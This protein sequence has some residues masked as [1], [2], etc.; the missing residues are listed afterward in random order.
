MPIFDRFR[1]GALLLGAAA[2]AA[3]EPGSK[4]TAQ[5]GYRGVGM[6]IPTD[7]QTQQARLAANVAP[8]PLPPA[9]PGPE[10]RWQNVQVLNGI[11]VNEFTRTMTAMSN[12]VAPKTGPNAGCNYCHNPA[13][14]ASDEKYA[15]VVARRMLAMTRDINSNWRSHVKQTGVTC[16]TCHAGNPVP[17]AGLWHQ[18]DANQYLRAYLD[19]TDLRVQSYTAL[20][21]S[22]NRSSIKQTEYTYAAM[23]NM[24]NSLGVNCT[25]CHNSRAWATWQDAPPTRVTAQYGLRMI[26]HINSGYVAPLGE[27]LPANRLG[28][29]GDAPL[30]GCATC[31]N[32]L[33]KPL[34]GAQMAKDYPALWGFGGAWN[35]TL[36]S[37]TALNGITDLRADDKIP[38]DGLAPR[39]PNPGA[40]DILPQSKPT[41]TPVRAATRPTAG[42]EVAQAS[43]QQ[44]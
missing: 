30:A 14:M 16:Y 34:A 12:W 25:F 13:N 26:R 24:S 29:R 36:P 19:K 33:H 15:K 22:N 20:P 5:V 38:H 32:G 11:S 1:F 41:A 40:P 7:P 4:N 31:H 9:P 21:T 17:R 39:R 10:G 2:L 43:Q 44:R 18:T 28:A 42:S 6:E 8:A 23:I 3:C 37:D 35:Q 27:V